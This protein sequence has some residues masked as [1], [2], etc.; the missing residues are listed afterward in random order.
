MNIAFLFDSTL[1][2]YAGFYKWPI[3]NKVF[4]TGIIQAYPRPRIIAK[5]VPSP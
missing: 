5:Q 3:N 2:E 4:S 1:P